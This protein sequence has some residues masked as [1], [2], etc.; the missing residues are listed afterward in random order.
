MTGVSDRRGD[1]PAPL[2]SS[3]TA[4][5][6]GANI[7][8]AELGNSLFF[9]VS[10]TGT[11]DAAV[12]SVGGT[13]VTRMQDT[14]HALAIAPLAAHAELRSHRDLELAGP[15]SIDPKRFERFASLIG[16]GEP[17]SP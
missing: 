6:F 7:T 15:V 8:T 11:P 1:T 9:V 17:R 4:E 10:Q 14:R 2:G 13:V 12:L 16:L 5:T 3:S